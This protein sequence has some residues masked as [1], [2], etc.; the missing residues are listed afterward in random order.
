MN[1]SREAFFSIAQC[2]IALGILD[3][4]IVG[5]HPCRAIV[6]AQSG[7]PETFQ[8]PEPWVGHIER[9]PILF[10]ASNPS[11]GDDKHALRSSPPDVIWDSNVR[12]FDEDA[13]YTIEG[14]YTMTAQGVRNPD[15]V[16][17]WAFVRNQ[18]SALFG[19]PAVPGV[20]YA[21]TEVAHCK[22]RSEI[23]VSDCATFCTDRHF[24]H[25]LDASGCRLIVAMGAHAHRELRRL[26]GIDTSSN[27]VEL[28]TRRRIA[29]VPHSNFRGS[30]KVEV[31]LA[32]HLDSIRSFLSVAERG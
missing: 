14:I 16:R 19:R 7:S 10:V 25:I 20:D 30:R 5:P 32:A 28:T 9:A 12:L 11:I 4:D 2:A 29:F 18:A 3:G 21:M 8:L 24:Q 22:S 31:V 1:S 27:Y 6:G 15:W 17:H 23:G 26:F 13:G